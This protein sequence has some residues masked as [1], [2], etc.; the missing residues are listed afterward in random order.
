MKPAPA[1]KIE[2]RLRDDA[3]GG[4]HRGQSG[5][6]VDGVDHHQRTA[7]LGPL[8]ATEAAGNAA[9]LETGVVRPVIREGSSENRAVEFASHRDVRHGKLH[10]VDPAV[11]LGPCHRSRLG[12]GL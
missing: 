1:G 5:L 2:R 6:E 3:A 8:A 10:V 7:R 12:G 4:L 9:V 11:M